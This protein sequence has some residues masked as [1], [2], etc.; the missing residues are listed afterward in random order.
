VLV[1][2]LLQS[3]VEAGEAIAA[4]S[5]LSILPKPQKELKLLS[6]RADSMARQYTQL[7]GSCLDTD[8]LD[9]LTLYPLLTGSTR[10]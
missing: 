9:I 7:K 10:S 5:F 3:A 6:L 1:R 2:A 4:S 8:P